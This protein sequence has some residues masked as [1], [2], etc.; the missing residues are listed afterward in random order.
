MNVLNAFPTKTMTKVFLPLSFAK[1]KLRFGRRL[2]LVSERNSSLLK[3]LNPRI[4]RHMAAVV[5]LT[6]PA[7]YRF[8]ATLLRRTGRRG[9]LSLSL[10][11]GI[12]IRPLKAVRKFPSLLLIMETL[13]AW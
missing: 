8:I 10:N 12:A 3:T 4:L 13:K 2:A 1:R 6:L 11:F 7:N 5:K 9:I